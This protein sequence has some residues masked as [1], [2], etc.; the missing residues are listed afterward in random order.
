MPERELTRALQSLAVGKIGQ[1]ILQKEPK[2]KDIGEI[3]VWVSEHSN[4]LIEQF[5]IKSRKLK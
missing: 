3:S 5:V 4:H 2:T 1:R